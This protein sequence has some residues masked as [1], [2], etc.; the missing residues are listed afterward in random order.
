MDF[1]KASADDDASPRAY[2]LEQSSQGIRP[3]RHA[4]RRWRKAFAGH[5]QEYRAAAAGDA[6]RAVVVDLDNKIVEMVVTLEP[7]AAVIAIQPY[8]LVVVSARRVFAPGVLGPDG[9]NRQE[10]PRPRMTVG[11]PPQLPWPKR[12]SWGPAVAFALIG[13]DAAA[14]ECDRYGLPISGQ[15]ASAGI[16]GGGANPD[17]GQRPITQGCMISD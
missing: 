8:R 4:S 14:P 16:A 6:W 13:P 11:A 10:C 17:R 1:R 7:V 5:V 3:Q 2:S 15:P 12:A 9:P